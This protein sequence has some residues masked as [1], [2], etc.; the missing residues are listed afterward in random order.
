LLF[1]PIMTSI[2]LMSNPSLLLALLSPFR[3]R[4]RAKRTW[5]LASMNC[6]FKPRSL[7]YCTAIAPN[8]VFFWQSQSRVFQR[9]SCWLL[10]SLIGSHL[11]PKQPK[12]GKQQTAAGKDCQDFCR[13][14]RLLPGCGPKMGFSPADFRFDSKPTCWQ[15]FLSLS[16]V[17]VA[18]KC[19]S[20]IF[21]CCC[22]LLGIS[23]I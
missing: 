21:F 10:M 18:V 20:L 1:Y 5:G 13:M 17:A 2:V 6:K 22:S 3:L 9:A 12:A 4:F 16:L 14:M 19:F 23:A 11:A 15:C 7:I 8:W